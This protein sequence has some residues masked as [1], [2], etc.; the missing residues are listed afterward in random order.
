M[1]FDFLFSVISTAMLCFCISSIL[2]PEKKYSYTILCTPLTLIEMFIFTYPSLLN[3]FL[4]IIL[5]CVTHACMLYIHKYKAVIYSISTTL[6]FFTALLFVNLLFVRS[7]SILNI[8]DFYG[9]PFGILYCM[10]DLGLLKI[11][12]YNK[13]NLSFLEENKTF[14][15]IGIILLILISLLMQALS[16][17]K[18]S[19]ST[20]ILMT[21][22]VFVLSLLFIFLFFQYRQNYLDKEKLRI[23][24]ENNDRINHIYDSLLKKEHRM[25]YVLR[26]LDHVISD[27]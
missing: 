3:N 20:I 19:Q 24:R 6:L 2:I 27:Q 15:L 13:N 14:G 9:F 12:K 16:F 8:G 4:L 10:I 23:Q 26:K 25:L 21:V 1:I 11:L 18:L 7:F 22:L 5:I 17:I